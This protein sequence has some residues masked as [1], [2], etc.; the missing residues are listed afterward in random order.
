M[1]GMDTR[2]IFPSIQTRQ[3]CLRRKR[4][5][6]K[7]P[8]MIIFKHP[9]IFLSNVVKVALINLADLINDFWSPFDEFKRPQ[10]LK[11]TE[12]LDSKAQQFEQ[13][14][15]NFYDQGIVYNSTIDAGNQPD[16]V[17]DQ[18]L[19]TG[20]TVAFWAI[21]YS[22]TKNSS[23][24]EMLRQGMN[25]LDLHQTAHGEPVRRLIRGV[26][27]PLDPK[28]T[29]IDDISN[30]GAT[31]HL[32]GIY[33]AWLYGDDDIKQKANTLIRGLADELLN[34]NYWC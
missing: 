30:D 9:I 21:K 20:I 5:Q 8:F 1:Y 10:I 3:S 33:Y 14:L 11:R 27:N 6:K 25:G 4:G 15:S 7:E 19:W 29:F 34:Y 24:L 22:V 32:F 16:D 28:N 12:S 18:S 26:T 13:A 23:D 2:K 31:G 17:G